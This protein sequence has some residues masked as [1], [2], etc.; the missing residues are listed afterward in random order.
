M[1]NLSMNNNRWIGYD[2]RVSCS[3]LSNF[4]S[5]ALQRIRIR[6]VESLSTRR[7]FSNILE[8]EER[9]I[10]YWYRI[11]LYILL[12]LLFSNCTYNDIL[13]VL[14]TD[15]TFDKRFIINLERTYFY[16]YD[17]WLLRFLNMVTFHRWYTCCLNGN[18]LRKSLQVFLPM[19]NRW[20]STHWPMRIVY[21]TYAYIYLSWCKFK[22]RGE[23]KKEHETLLLWNSICFN[24]DAPWKRCLL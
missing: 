19:L 8:G 5:V 6:H 18:F 15:K 3:R 16:Y 12:S 24:N 13:N 21:Y 14:V 17:K 7:F 2:E 11:L 10:L 1:D 22:E 4:C 23:K 20:R 9:E